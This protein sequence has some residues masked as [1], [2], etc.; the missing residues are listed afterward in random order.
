MTATLLFGG[1][2]LE[3]VSPM[4][5]KVI[6]EIRFPFSLFDIIIYLTQRAQLSIIFIVQQTRVLIFP[7]PSPL[8]SCGLGQVKETGPHGGSVFCRKLQIS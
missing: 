6:F 2:R 4:E 5:R 7:L 3:F 1:L 8:G